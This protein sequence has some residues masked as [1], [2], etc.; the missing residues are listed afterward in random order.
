[1]ETS[2]AVEIET[3][4]M[5]VSGVISLFVSIFGWKI[6]GKLDDN[7]NAIDEMRK[8]GDETRTIVREIRIQTAENHAILDRMNGH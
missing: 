5:A 6:W 8:Q 3:L 7:K 1:M 4:I 2:A